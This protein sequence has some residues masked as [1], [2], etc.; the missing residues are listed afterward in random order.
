MVYFIYFVIVVSFF[1]NFA[2]L[3]IISPYA[4][5]L[6]GSSFFIG[7]TVGMYSFSNLLG[8]ICA[9]QW[10]DR[11]GRKRIMVIGMFMAGASLVFY[12]LVQTVEQLVAVRFFHGIGGGL[13]V[14][15]AFAFLGDRSSRKGVRQGK[16]MA[17]SGAAIGISA[18]LAPAY[19][20]FVSQKIGLSWV[21]FSIALL[22]IVTAALVLFYLPD[23]YQWNP[24]H[25]AQNMPIFPLLKRPHL[26]Q[27][28]MGAFALMFGVGILTQMLPLKI[29]DLGYGSAMSG[30]L[31]SIYGLVAIVLF[32]LPTNRLSDRI[33]RLRPMIYGIVAISIALLLLSGVH[34]RLALMAAMVVFGTGFALLFP[35]MSALVVDQT[36]AAERGRAFALFYA[37]Y[38]L[39]VVVGPLFVGALGVSPDRGLLIGACG[40][41]MIG[42]ILYVR[43]RFMI[44]QPEKRGL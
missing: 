8:N 15:A 16:A 25:A 1:D 24:K 21:F 6:G 9:G 3:P 26:L 38:S 14:P 40:I 34:E 10:I 20:G 31:M 28:Y 43:G 29:E 39:G 13:L 2:Q 36:E 17:L 27:A 44:H 35:A 30:M 7:L 32:V 11:F 18:I 33:G 19:G 22:M 37:A 5:E 23:K 41:L 42:A 4:Q 12:A